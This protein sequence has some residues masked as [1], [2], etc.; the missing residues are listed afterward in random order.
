VLNC[1]MYDVLP[2]D[3]SFKSKQDMIPL[4]G[5]SRSENLQ[6]ISCV[7]PG[8]SASAVRILANIYMH[9]AYGTATRAVLLAE[10][11]CNCV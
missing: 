9:Q 8:G 7:G 1:L 11:P 6:R 4:L 3:M 5:L 2:H 10:P